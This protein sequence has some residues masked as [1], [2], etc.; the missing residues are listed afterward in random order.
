M[1]ATNFKLGFTTNESDFKRENTIQSFARLEIIGEKTGIE[2]KKLNISDI[3]QRKTKRDN[4]SAIFQERPKT[5]YGGAND[6][7]RT[8]NNEFYR[9]I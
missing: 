5:M 4:V 9:W 7:L 2:K 8:V 3:I 6:R 1:R